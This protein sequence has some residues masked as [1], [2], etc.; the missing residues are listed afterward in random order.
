[1]KLLTTIA[2]LLMTISAYSQA[3]FEYNNGAFSQNGE[4]L[5][6]KQISDITIAYNLGRI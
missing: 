3:I 5:S 2:V 4:E 1:M 6:L